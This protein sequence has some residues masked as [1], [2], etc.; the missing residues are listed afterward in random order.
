MIAGAFTDDVGLSREHAREWRQFVR[1][2][3]AADLIALPAS[4]C[5]VLAYLSEY[6][7]TLAT[8]RG[9][10]TALN[11]A[12]QRA[13]QP[14][15]GAAEAVRRV[16]NPGRA[17]RLHAVRLYADLAVAR[18]PMFGWPEAL[19][20]RRD[21][22][23]VLL[24]ASGL[25]WRQ[26]AEL[27]QRDVI[28]T[29]DEVQLGSQPLLSLPATHQRDTCPVEIFRRWHE[30]LV[31]APSAV[32]HRHLCVLLS[33]PHSDGDDSALVSL[34][35]EYRDQPLLCDFDSRGMAVGVVAELDPLSADQIATIA[36]AR[37]LGPKTRS[38]LPGDLDQGYHERGIA[39]RWRAQPL[40][41]E[42]D[43]L[44]DKVDTIAARFG[45]Y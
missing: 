35:G 10:L 16:L 19:I 37:L 30:I 6:P 32:G 27:K 18:L 7:G 39:A 28:L 33:E 21:A 3:A 43:E 41:N 12:H 15:P 45:I 1:W 44:L 17:E 22:V 14:I 40:L 5:T 8:Q 38:A 42:L 4:A 24:A 31:H 13:R 34:P 25:T 26:V 2:A 11:A 9:R 29:E 23:I 36:S 20:G